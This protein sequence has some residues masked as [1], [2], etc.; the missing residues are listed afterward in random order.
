M[1]AD[2]LITLP[3]KDQK[4][5]FKFEDRAKLPPPNIAFQ[6]VA[7][8]YDG[9]VKHALY[10]NLEFGIDMDS[11]VA[12]VGKNG[13]GKSTLVNLIMGDLLPIRGSVSRHTSLKLAKY[14]QHSADQL[15][16]NKTPLQY[17]MDKYKEKYPGKEVAFWRQ[18]LGRFGISGSH[19]TSEIR[20]LS[21]GLKA[22]V[23]F[24]QLALESPHI[25]LLDEPTNHLDIQS[26][27]ALAKACAEFSGGIVLVSHDFRLIRQVAQEIWEVKDK[28]V[29]KID[30]TIEE[31]KKT[32]ADE[33]A[34]QVALAGA[35]ARV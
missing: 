3:L 18:Q 27:D 26:I 13:T 25:I 8:A 28:K 21:D 22:R 17:F 4:I 20:V 7:F 32:L 9:D 29:V 11:R 23:V 15:P 12:I 16:Y 6:D 24:S 31:Y 30:M 33:S 35:R 10:K 14:S 5:S 1:E 34:E 19:Q 2:G